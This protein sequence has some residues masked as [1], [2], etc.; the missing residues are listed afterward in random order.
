MKEFAEEIDSL[1]KSIFDTSSSD[2]TSAV[3]GL[4]KEKMVALVPKL[5]EMFK[6][7]TEHMD[8]EEAELFPITRALGE[9]ELPTFTKIYYHCRPVREKLLPFVLEFLS[10]PERM[11][12]KW[13]E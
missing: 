6:A 9:K 2:D 12:C 4:A 3:I 1:W 11:Q 8:G 13:G 10:G 5:E 7:M